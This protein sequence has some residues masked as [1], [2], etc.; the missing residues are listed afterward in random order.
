MQFYTPEAVNYSFISLDNE[1]LAWKGE[2]YTMFMSATDRYEVPDAILDL[3]VSPTPQFQFLR[4]RDVEIYAPST[5]FLISAGGRFRSQFGYFTA[6]NHQYAVSTI[7]IPAHSG[8]KRSEMFYIDG[9]S[10]WEKKNNLCVAPGFACGENF[11]APVAPTAVVGGWQFFDTPDFYLAAFEQKPYVM[12]EV[13]ERTTSFAAFQAEVLKNQIRL[14]KGVSTTYRSSTGRTITFT[15]ESGKLG[16]Y[17][18]SA[19]NGVQQEQD[20]A[21][22]PFLRGTVLQS[23]GD[24]LITILNPNTRQKIVLDNRDVQNPVRREERY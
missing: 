15:P 23:R 10:A 12:I 4:H 14:K 21:K 2:T 8:L 19:I 9:P 18:I 16:R 17:P 5:N 22:W 3:F 11:H 20:S 7:V 1:K 24:G 13:R 6:E